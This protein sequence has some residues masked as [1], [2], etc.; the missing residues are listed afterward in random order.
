MR[1]E[2][3]VI[4]ATMT[5]MMPKRMSRPDRYSFFLSQPSFPACFLL[6]AQRPVKSESRPVLAIAMHAGALARQNVNLSSLKRLALQKLPD[7]PLRDDI[8][9]QP[10]EITPEEYV[11]NCRVWL[12]MLRLPSQP[13]HGPS[14]G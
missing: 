7:G 4:S 1:L 14:V 8:L 5:T 6:I 12:R 10:D 13:E 9:A 11:A 3:L 2:P